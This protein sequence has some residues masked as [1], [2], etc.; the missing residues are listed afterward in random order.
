ME[1][2]RKLGRVVD[3]PCEIP[4]NYDT[5]CLDCPSFEDCQLTEIGGLKSELSPDEDY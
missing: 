4:D 3:K 1:R 5:N 2:K